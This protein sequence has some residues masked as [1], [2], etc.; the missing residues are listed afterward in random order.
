VVVVSEPLRNQDHAAK[1]TVEIRYSLVD[2]SQTL[3]A[4]Q[5]QA[6][7]NYLSQDKHFLQNATDLDLTGQRFDL[8]IANEVIADFPVAS[9]A[10]ARRTNMEKCGRVTEL[11][12][13]PA[14]HS[15]KKT[16]L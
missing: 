3:F 4:A 16:R 2:L 7:G 6:L 5:Q 13:S 12:Q 9:V 8:I 1:R 14:F 10:R 15:L 11:S